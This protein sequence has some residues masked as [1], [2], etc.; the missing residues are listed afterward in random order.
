MPYKKKIVRKK[1]QYKR[2]PKNKSKITAKNKNIIKINLSGSG[3]GGSSSVIPIPYPSV[4][5]QMFPTTAPLNIYNTMSRN[6][7]ETEYKTENEK[8]QEQE[9][10]SR[11]SVS[12]Q[13]EPITTN[14]IFTQIKRIPESISTQTKPI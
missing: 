14:S 9:T 2:T 5:S 11:S 6:P 4:A 12:I 13:T 10:V 3:G 8:F 1:R 7:V